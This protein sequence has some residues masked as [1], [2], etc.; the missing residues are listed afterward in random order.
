MG[1]A[2]GSASSKLIEVLDKLDA[3]LETL[4]QRLQ[5]LEHQ[6]ADSNGGATIRHQGFS[7][8]HKI[9]PDGSTQL[10]QITLK[11]GRLLKAVQ[12]LSSPCVG[13]HLPSKDAPKR[14]EF[15]YPFTDL[16]PYGDY[17][18][19]AV[20]AFESPEATR[21]GFV[22]PPHAFTDRLA[23]DI[24]RLL[25]C[26]DN[27]SAT[28]VK[29]RDENLARGVVLFDDLPSL[30]APGTAHHGPKGQIVEVSSCHMV[31]DG[32]CVVD[33]WHFRWD[34]RAFF[35][36]RSHFEVDRYTGTRPINGL[37][38]PPLVRPRPKALLSHLLSRNAANLKSLSEILQVK[39]GDYPLCIWRTDLRTA[40]GN[41]RETV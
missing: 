20:D 31:P 24:R 22:F 5:S 11:K 27:S 21:F 26:I 28:A 3:R 15:S 16:L 8:K 38:Y 32:G 9:N 17:L 40:M 19:L 30:Y 12:Q 39:P 18:R 36:A 2:N 29:R 1:P 10:Q 37:R 33:V 7:I 6:Q 34:G 23:V 4:N 14:K 13:R 25:S 35:R 41:A